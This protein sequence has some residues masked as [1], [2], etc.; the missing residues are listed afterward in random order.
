LKS[1]VP[2]SAPLPAPNLRKNGIGVELLDK[3]YSG[4]EGVEISLVYPGSVAANGKIFAG[5]RLLSVGVEKAA[6]TNVNRCSQAKKLLEK[7]VG[8]HV[9]V[10]VEF[11]NT[12]FKG[13][14]T[15][16]VHLTLE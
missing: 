7:K 2:A 9:R 10:E 13:Y 8:T 4:F 12:K 11:F 15:K 16:T 1:S 3:N 5:N 6:P 14:G